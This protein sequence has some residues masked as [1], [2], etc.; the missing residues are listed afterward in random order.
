[1]AAPIMK[2]V[3]KLESVLM[4]K[5]RFFKPLKISIEEII[6]PPMAAIIGTQE[7]RAL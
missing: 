3:R 1:M 5:C 2:I 6:M 7:C 4:P